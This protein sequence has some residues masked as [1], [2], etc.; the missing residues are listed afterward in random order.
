MSLR[1]PLATVPEGAKVTEAVTAMVKSGQGVIGVLREER[2]VGVFT[3]H[4][5]AERVLMVKRDPESTSIGDVMTKG[6]HTVP[7]D[8]STELAF[9]K[10]VEKSVGYLPVVDD[11]GRP[12]GM[13]EFR[14]LLLHRLRDVTGQLESI[15]RYF[16]T[17]SIGGD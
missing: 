14:S 7:A 11:N 1:V 16:A 2:L 8:A 10:L 5:L 15:I 9:R 12:H 4:D 17:D 13:F 3:Y 6:M